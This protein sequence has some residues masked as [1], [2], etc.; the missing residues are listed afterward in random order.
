METET[1][2]AVY[3]EYCYDLYLR[4]CPYFQD[5]GFWAFGRFFG[6]NTSVT[7]FLGN[8]GETKC[9]NLIPQF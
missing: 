7:F 6:H 1:C 2:S 8:F 4:N 9:E 5:N 3:S